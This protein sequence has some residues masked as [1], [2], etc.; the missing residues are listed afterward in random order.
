MRP[1]KF[2]PFPSARIG[3]LRFPLLFRKA[4]EDSL[5]LRTRCC[6]MRAVSRRASFCPLSFDFLALFWTKIARSKEFLREESRS[7]ASLLSP[8]LAL[9]PFFLF[10]FR[11][12][13]R[14]PGTKKRFSIAGAVFARRPFG[15]SSCLFF[16]FLSISFPDLFS[17]SESA[18]ESVGYRSCYSVCAR[19]RRSRA[20][21]IACFSD[22]PSFSPLFGGDF[23]E[24][25]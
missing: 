23:L 10:P 3:F 14:T 16:P 5:T 1:R 11:F 25:T 4:W 6:T 24:S 15:S 20:Q 18:C 21:F 12:P 9:P 2:S 17:F 19:S 7:S 8:F 22:L 13:L